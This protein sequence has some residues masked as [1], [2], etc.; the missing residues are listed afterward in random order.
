MVSCWL[1]VCP[2]VC[3]TYVRPSVFSFPDDNL[4]KCQWIFTN[5]DMYIDIVEVWSGTADG[6]PYFHF[7]MITLVNIN[8][9]SLS[10]VCALI[11]WRFSLGLLMGKFYQILTE[12]S[13]YDFS[14]FSYPNDNQ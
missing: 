3:C 6:H 1:S 8:E 13:A 14:V 10:L 4:N 7:R 9:F 5:T 12:L 11:L 2:S